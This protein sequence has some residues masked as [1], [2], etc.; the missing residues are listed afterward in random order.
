MELASILA[1]ERFSDRPISVCPIVG[2]VMRVYNDAINRRRRQDLYRY[3]SECVGTRDGYALQRR[4]ALRAL[5][6]GRVQF[7]RKR[8]RRWLCRAP[9]ADDCPEAIALYLIRSIGR[10]THHTHAVMLS[11]LD[12]LIAMR[13]LPVEPPRTGPMLHHAGV[14]SR[15]RSGERSGGVFGGHSRAARSGRAVRAG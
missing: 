4:R 12:D 5:E 8:W 10:H 13:T 9:D 11:L 15:I 14:R 2:A 3:A 7:A 6:L 1:G